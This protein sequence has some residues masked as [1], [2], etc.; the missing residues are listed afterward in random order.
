MD[1]PCILSKAGTGY[2]VAALI[3]TGANGYAFIDRHLVKTL[4]QMR[5]P[6][7]QSLP[8]SIP[9]KGHDCVAR[10]PI[11]QFIHLNLNIDSRV[12]SFTPF[13]ITD[14]GNYGIILVCKYLAY[15]SV[16]PDEQHRQ[17]I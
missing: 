14:L 13:L 9:V 8:N 16:L 11:N 15:Y 5:S 17:F 2:H 6:H 10:R 7:I 3:D 4:F 12:H 1:F